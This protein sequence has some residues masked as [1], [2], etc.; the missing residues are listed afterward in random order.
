MK[1]VILESPYAAN[2]LYSVEEHVRY[3]RA[4]LRASCY[5]GEAP[6]ASHLLYTQALDDDDP[7][8]RQMGIEAGLTWRHASEATVVYQDYGISKG[9]EYGIKLAE[10]L[11]KPVI[12]RSL[13]GWP[14]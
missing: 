3:A 10:E 11:G 6:M 7:V 1:L 14:K 2:N 13:E 12:Y 5:L 9:M 4:A 8:E